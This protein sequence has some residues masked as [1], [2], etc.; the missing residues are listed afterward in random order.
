MIAFLFVGIAAALNAVMDILEN[1]NFYS[2]I[3]RD[4]DNSFWYKR[5]SW[6]GARKVFGWK[7]D[8]WHCAKSL[9]V[10]FLAFAIL[11]YSEVFSPLYDL[12][13]IGAIWNLVFGFTYKVLK[14]G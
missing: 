10:V 9:M 6:R 5:E 1:E 7:F 8:G 11:T 13:L 14:N 2:S 4:Y 12:L 3:F